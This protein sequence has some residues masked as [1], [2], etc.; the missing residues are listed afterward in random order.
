MT[1][2]IKYER[3][4]VSGEQDIRR[5]HTMKVMRIGGELIS[6]VCI[7]TKCALTVI[8]IQCAFGQSTSILR[9]FEASLK[10]NC[11][12]AR[13]N[14]GV[15]YSRVMDCIRKQAI[16]KEILIVMLLPCLGKILY[17]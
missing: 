6:I 2:Y 4:Q 10:A 11:I 13:I 3:N 12:I 15:I 17:L 1:L 5:V 7:H 16:R 8:L 14:V 9:W